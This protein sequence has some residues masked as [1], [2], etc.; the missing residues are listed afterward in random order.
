MFRIV[1]GQKKK[2][3]KKKKSLTKSLK[4]S[5]ILCET[6]LRNLKDTHSNLVYQPTSDRFYIP[7]RRYQI[8]HNKIL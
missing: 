8:S 6:P 5:L 3:K 4:F 2:K 7:K 1:R